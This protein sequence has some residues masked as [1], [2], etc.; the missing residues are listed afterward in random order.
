MKGNFIF[1][2]L[3]RKA[4]RLFLKKISQVPFEATH[5]DDPSSD[6]IDFIIRN[7]FSATPD[8]PSFV[9]QPKQGSVDYTGNPFTKVA[10]LYADSEYIA[11]EHPQS[12]FV[13]LY[14]NSD[15]ETV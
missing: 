2:E 6:T 7:G 11:I 1:Q 9:V 4:I 3:D 10:L 15:T 13:K 5:R 12:F 14:Y 8:E